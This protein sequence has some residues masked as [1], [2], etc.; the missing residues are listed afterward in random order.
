[1]SSVLQKIGAFFGRRPPVPA[2]PE[3]DNRRQAVQAR[4]ENAQYTEENRRNWFMSDY[5]SAKAA[6]NFQVRRTL[7]MRSRQEVSNNPYMWGVANDN[8]ND[9]INKGPTLKVL[10]DDKAYNEA[11]ESGWKDW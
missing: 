4:Y 2:R 5:F 6:N 7:R 8:A 9:L 11:Y 10:T 1:M 3:P